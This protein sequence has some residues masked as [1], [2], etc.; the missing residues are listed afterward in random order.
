[1][2]DECHLAYYSATKCH[3]RWNVSRGVLRIRLTYC[4]SVEPA[5]DIPLCDMQGRP[6]SDRMLTAPFPTFCGNVPVG[7]HRQPMPCAGFYKSSLSPFVKNRC[8][9]CLQPCERRPAASQ[10]RTRANA[11]NWYGRLPYKGQPSS[12]VFL[13]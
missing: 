5:F 2:C 8:R 11:P 6:H 1:M 10:Q 3:V 7:A 9:N 13:S 4:A 12:M